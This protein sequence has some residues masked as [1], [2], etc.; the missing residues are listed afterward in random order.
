MPLAFIFLLY[1][2]AELLGYSGPISVLVFGVVLANSKQ[3][4]LNIVNRFGADHLTEFTSIERTL[5]SEV[6][7]LVKTFFF[8]FLGMSIQFGNLKILLIGIILTGIIYMGRLILCRILTSKDTPTSDA[9]MISFII[10]KG[11]AAAV[12]A[13]VPMHMGLPVEILPTFIE[14]R[15][16]IYMVILFSIVFTAILIYCQETGLTN[17]FYKRF[18]DSS[19]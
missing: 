18:L 8:I 16:L 12:L 19:D 2:S 6:I 14:I 1:G 11:L 17:T 13:E 7:F 5:F 15:A 3:I 4:P 9:A 10:P